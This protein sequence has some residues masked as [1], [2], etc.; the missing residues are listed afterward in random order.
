MRH[1]LLTLLLTLA[2]C[3]GG[4]NLPELPPRNALPI[5]SRVNLAYEDVLDEPRN[6]GY[7]GKLG[8]I[9]QRYG[10]LIHAE[11][12]Y[13]RAYMLEPAEFRWQ[14]Y[15]A[16]IQFSLDQ[17]D[18]AVGAYR[19]ALRTNPDYAAAKLQ[20]AAITFRMGNLVECGQLSEE[21]LGTEVAAPMAS[22]WLGRI[23]EHQRNHAQAL[24]RYTA[25][26]D[27][28][29]KFGEAHFRL[30]LTFTALGDLSGA[31]EHFILADR[32]KF[33]EP[34]VPDPLL[35]DAVG[36]S[37]RVADLLAAGYAHEGQGRFEDAVESYLEVISADPGSDAAHARLVYLYAQ[38]ESE[39]EAMRHYQASKELNPEQSDAYAGY[40]YLLL[41]QN[42]YQEAESTLEH[43]LRLNP[44]HPE[45]LVRR[46]L[47][48]ERNGK[49]DQAEAMYQKA[50]ECRPG[51]RDAHLG[52]GR[53]LLHARRYQE[54]FAEF[55]AVV[56][57]EDE[58]TPELFYELSSLY[59]MAGDRAR[60]TECIRKAHELAKKYGQ[61]KLLDTIE[62]RGRR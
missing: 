60:A 22:Y 49:H 9:L 35:A 24:S 52:L 48:L 5:P 30:G 4:L 23:A 59:T 34:P 14:Y 37:H 51:Y 27:R 10:D 46:G 61:A 8:M 1:F 11:T 7:N 39:A 38:A 40:G 43:A 28:F 33:I 54:A 47:L 29:P 21:L 13:R 53:T 36:D 25:A 15:L 62:A 41:E 45:A 2:S 12:F 20:L 26:C 16:Q 32:H 55:E 31:R 44:Y 50:A 57:R 17:Y 56:A 6:P 58:R 3:T 18:L 19:R 42:R